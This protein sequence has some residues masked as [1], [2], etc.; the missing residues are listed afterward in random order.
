[1]DL[2]HQQKQEITQV[3]RMQA[4]MQISMML[5]KPREVFWKMIND[6]ENSS[7]FRKLHG[8]RG[9]H[10]AIRIKPIK[11]A[12]LLPDSHFAAS[13][14]VDVESLIQGRDDLISRIRDM[15]IEK[16][17][18]YFL[19]GEGTDAEISELLD[20]DPDR[21]R[22]FRKGIIDRIQIF[23]SVYAPSSSYAGAGSISPLE[24][25]ADIYPLKDQIQVDFARHKTRYD[26]DE[27]QIDKFLKEG[28]LTG[29]EAKEVRSLVAGMKRINE[30]FNLLNRIIKTVVDEQKV[31]LI[32]GNEEKLKLLEGKKVAELLEVDPSWISRVIKGKYIRV[33]TRIIPLRDLFISEKELKKKV[34]K[35]RVRKILKEEKEKLLKGTILTPYSD[36]HLALILENRF[37]TTYSRRTINNWRREIAKEDRR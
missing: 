26:I 15:G 37:R 30:R 4:G 22:E 7:V 2:Y 12:I 1:M 6:L 17:R 19:E 9:D 3:Q 24:V 5:E 31:F 27:K 21:I 23:D 18:F 32:T 29:D 28:K 13:G 33:R 34:G 25:A 10:R 20:I 36:Q 16:F 8:I 35:C 11:K 14:S